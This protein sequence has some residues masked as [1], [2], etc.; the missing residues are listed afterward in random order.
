MVCLTIEV[1]ESNWVYVQSTDHMFNYGSIG[2]LDGNTARRV[3]LL[4]EKFFKE[5][6]NAKEHPL[7]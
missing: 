6:P 1:S 7:L 3:D 4:V 2:R 5:Y